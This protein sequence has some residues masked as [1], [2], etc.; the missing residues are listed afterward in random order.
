[1]T[2]KAIW[3]MACVI[4]SQ[5]ARLM[6]HPQWRMLLAPQRENGKP[7]KLCIDDK[8][9]GSFH[10]A[11]IQTSFLR[12]ENRFTPIL[13]VVNQVCIAKMLGCHQE[14]YIQSASCAYT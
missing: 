9:G 12:A 5:G 1:M 4:V 2:L 10:V 13:T 14:I 3:G 8:Q 11:F 6:T 7:N